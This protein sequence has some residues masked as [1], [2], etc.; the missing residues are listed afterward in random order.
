MTMIL[1]DK[2]HA[3]G[4]DYSHRLLSF[5]RYKLNDPGASL[6]V[7]KEGKWVLKSHGS[8]WFVKRF[9][10]QLKFLLQE[11]LIST[12]LS[13]KFYHVLPFHPIHERELLLFEGSP[14]GITMWL[15]TSRAI[16]YDQADDR[17]DALLVMK[18][19]HAVSK[20]IH[21]SWTEEIP[22]YHWLKKWKKRLMQFQY[23]LPYLQ[24]FIQ[25]YYLYTYL[26]WGK[27][28]LKEL[29][30]VG[31]HEYGDCITHGDVAHHNFLRGKNGTVYLIDFDLMSL[32]TEIT[33]D[34]Q[35]CNRILPYLNWSLGGIKEMGPFHTYRD[36]LIFHI[37][38]MYPSDVFRE[39][40]RFIRE[41]QSYKQRVW[42]YL[43]NLTIQQFS[44]R[45]QFNQELHGEVK[46]INT[47]L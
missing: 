8:K 23:N 14:I 10:S 6:K 3:R 9:P 22:H 7:I 1:R 17:E 30:S 26:E 16:Q 37:A 41:D 15:E 32:S 39:W 11:R 12:L 42:G 46:R 33:D 34:L 4:D 31:I 21:G 20:R 18:K 38:L 2:M 5:L 36:H 40:N 24:A 43:T 27:W 28:A 45:M 25:P 19:F 35:Y 29:K 47:Q 13:E 44:K